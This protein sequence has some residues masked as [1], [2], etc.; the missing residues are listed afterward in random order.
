MGFGFMYLKISSFTTSAM[1]KWLHNMA[2]NKTE[3]LAFDFD[4]EELTSDDNDTEFTY[5]LSEDS[6]NGMAQ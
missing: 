2:A 3:E 1:A 4:S 5:D 6:D